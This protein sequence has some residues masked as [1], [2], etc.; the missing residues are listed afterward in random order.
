MSLR[1]LGSFRGRNREVAAS[2]AVAALSLLATLILLAGFWAWLA[3][4]AKAV[5]SWGLVGDVAAARMVAFLRS[6]GVAPRLPLIAWNPRRPVPWAFIDLVILLG[7]GICVSMV[8]AELN[9][10]FH[11][12]PDSRKIKEVTLAE[13]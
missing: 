13:L 2:P 12:L 3:A 7:I 10:R 11:W 1:R 9:H 8:F 5:I 6:L 4:A